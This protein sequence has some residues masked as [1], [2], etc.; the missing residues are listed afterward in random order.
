VKKVRGKCAKDSTFFHIDLESCSFKHVQELLDRVGHLLLSV[1]RNNK[2]VC[3]SQKR[4]FVDFSL[5]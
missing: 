4:A 3:I 2:I 1:A 5:K